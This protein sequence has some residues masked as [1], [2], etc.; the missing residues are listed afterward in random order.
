M[1]GVSFMS[2]L[3]LV[4]VPNE[5]VVAFSRT[6]RLCISILPKRRLHDFFRFAAAIAP[7]ISGDKN[8]PT[9]TGEV[10]RS[11]R[12][13]LKIRTLDGR[14]G[15]GLDTAFDATHSIYVAREYL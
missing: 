2:R 15:S 13:A 1:L 14:N 9:E 4:D 10:I 5:V 11:R 3:R 12:K 8:G 7:L 6:W